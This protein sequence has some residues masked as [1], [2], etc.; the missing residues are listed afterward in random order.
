[1]PGEVEMAAS[2]GAEGGSSVS[3]VADTPGKP[4][5]VDLT[6]TLAVMQYRKIF[7]YHRGAYK[8]SRPMAMLL[9]FVVMAGLTIFDTLLIIK[10]PTG[11]V[12]SFSTQFGPGREGAVQIWALLGL[13]FAAFVQMKLKQLYSLQWLHSMAT[14]T[15]A[16]QVALP[17]SR[18][19]RPTE[20]N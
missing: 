11:T 3:V 8:K 13:A 4:Q 17:Y 14:I 6:E 19:L 15:V 5:Q 2:R 1:M 20:T 7:R 18:L 10:L 16:L 9:L 12:V